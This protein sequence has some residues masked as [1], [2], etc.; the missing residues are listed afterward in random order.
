[1]FNKTLGRLAIISVAAVVLLGSQVNAHAAIAPALG[2]KGTPSRSDV[3]RPSTSKPC[4]SAN[5]ADVRTSTGVNTNAD[6]SV[7]MTITNFNACVGHRIQR[8]DG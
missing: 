5:L 1:M 7:T 2:V 8:V 3:Q 4:G 6:G